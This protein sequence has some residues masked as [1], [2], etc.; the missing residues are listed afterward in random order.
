MLEPDQFL[1]V[2]P[3]LVPGIGVDVLKMSWSQIRSKAAND[4]EKTARYSSTLSLK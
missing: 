2:F 1:D 4:S 3:D